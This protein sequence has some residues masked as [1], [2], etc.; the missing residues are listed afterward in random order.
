M[1]S[2]LHTLGPK[3]VFRSGTSIPGQ[4]WHV[5]YKRTCKP[6]NAVSNGVEHPGLQLSEYVGAVSTRT[7]VVRPSQLD[8][9]VLIDFLA[10]RTR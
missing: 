8:R 10:R 2:T 4:M 6:Q 5:V 1:H 9:M 3:R 7:S